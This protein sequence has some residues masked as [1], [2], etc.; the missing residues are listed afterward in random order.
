[1]QNDIAGI[2]PVSKGGFSPSPLPEPTGQSDSQTR[3]ET[4]LRIIVPI[5]DGLG[6]V[7]GRAIFTVAPT[8]PIPEA[9]IIGPEGVRV[10]AP[11]AHTH[12]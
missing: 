11:L 8:D 2:L 9:W 3:R 6:R 1:M 5:R 12:E 7:V 10:A 4:E